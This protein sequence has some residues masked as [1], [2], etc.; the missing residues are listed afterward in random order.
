MTDLTQ[1]LEALKLVDVNNVL[2][3]IDQSRQCLA[4][5]GDNPGPCQR[6]RQQL[7]PRCGSN[8][9]LLQWQAAQS[10]PST[11]VRLLRSRAAVSRQSALVMCSQLHGCC[12]FI[13]GTEWQII[14]G[15]ASGGSANLPILTTNANWYVNGT[16]GSDTAYDGTSAT[17]VAGTTHGPFKTIQRAAAEVLKYNM[18]GYNQFINVAD[19]NYTGPVNCTQP[20]GAGTIR[21]VGNT[22]NPQNCTLT[23]TGVNQSCFFVTGGAWWFNGFRLSTTGTAMDG[24]SVNGSGATGLVTGSMRFGPCCPLT[25]VGSMERPADN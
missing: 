1:L 15:A 16:T 4:M 7:A 10:F 18:N 11:A 20:N 12:C 5:V 17:V 8:R 23:T 3:V 22:V 19:G 6:Q 13:D 24:I 14:A 2:K 25:Y 21:I 9:D